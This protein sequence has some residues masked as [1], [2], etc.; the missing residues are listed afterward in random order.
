MA[1]A[2]V[3]GNRVVWR[4]D[5]GF[6]DAE[7]QHPVG[8][9]TEFCIASVSKTMAA[10]IL[11]QL[12]DAGM[13]GLDDPVS[14]YLTDSGMPANITI[15]EVM[16]HTSDG[17]PGEEFLY[18]G[19]RYAA[20]SQI[21][22]KL[23]GKPY[24][25]VLS[26]RI[27]RP[28]KMAHTIPGLDAPGYEV[29]QQQLAKPYDWDADSS[30]GIKQGELPRPGLSAATGIVSTEDDL[31]LYA[32][33][34]DGSAV[35][36]PRS[37]TAMFTPTRS[38]RGE[39]LPYG[40]GWFVQDYMGERL[41]WHFGQEDS[42]ASLFLRVPERKLTVI[43]LANSNALSD[44]FRLLDGNAAR[45]LVAL[46]FLKDVVLSDKPL[47]AAAQG[48]LEADHNL[49]EALARIYLNQRDQAVPFARRALDAGTVQLHPD[50]S[51]LYLLMRLNERTFNG[52]T[53]AIGTELGREHPNLPTALFYFG[54]FY[55][56]TDRPEKAM[57]LFQRIADIQPPLRHW[58]AALALLELGKWYSG[59][60]P[61][62]ARKYL[63]RVIEMN[64]NVEGAVDR[65]QQ[66]LKVIPQL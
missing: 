42:Y 30:G 49:D 27:L 54:T 17:A 52:A 25:A 1:A 60:N 41:V 57:P 9:D 47:D 10:V 26:D 40:L 24:A 64:L 4:Q 7:K 2:I 55:E 46:D 19:A 59:R 22:E 56:Q 62:Q 20:L 43:V 58:T 23:T 5:F 37:K 14:K 44:A 45:S 6:A 38:S 48:Q 29:L 28:L 18:N 66:A 31:A 3:E 12:R 51:T 16:S 61:D 50:V 11:M 35:A 36:S 21:I 13:L 34:L 33:A 39:N 63:R 8:P 15:R 53:E 65:A 32:M